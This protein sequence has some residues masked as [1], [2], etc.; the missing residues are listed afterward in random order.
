MNRGELQL[1]LRAIQ[2]RKIRE[3]GKQVRHHPATATITPITMI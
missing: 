3:D 2:A 1:A